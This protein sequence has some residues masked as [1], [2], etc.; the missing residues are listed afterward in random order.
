M[1]NR[2]HLV[3][4]SSRLRDKIDDYLDKQNPNRDI[5]AIPAMAS[6][7]D[8]AQRIISWR[9]DDLLDGLLYDD[10]KWEGKE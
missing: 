6:V 10:V 7:Y 2:Y 8:A 3:A 4:F 1:I 9:N 5:N